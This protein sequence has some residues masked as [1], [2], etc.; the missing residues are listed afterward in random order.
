MMKKLALALLAVGVIAFSG[1][2][3]KSCCP[4]PKTCET[5]CTVTDTR[6]CTGAAWAEDENVDVVTPDVKKQKELA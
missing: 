6:S 5:S 2:C 1:C 4:C 3:R